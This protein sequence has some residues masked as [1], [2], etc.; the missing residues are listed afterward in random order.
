MVLTLEMLLAEARN[1]Q[2][3]CVAGFKGLSRQVLDTNIIDSP[4]ILT[5]LKGGELV[6][7]TGYVLTNNRPMIRT[8]VPDLVNKGCAGLAFK[9]KRYF[10]EIPQVILDQGN[11]LDFPILELSYDMRMSDL[12]HFVYSNIFKKELST[13]EQIYNLY[14][15]VT[16]ALVSDKDISLSLYEIS[17]HIQNPVFL[18]DGEMNLTAYEL[19]ENC[20]DE[21]RGLM[22][23]TL[24]EAAL[25][26]RL[27]EDILTLY[28]TSRFR[29]H[30]VVLG[31][32]ER[33]VNLQL[34]SL[35][36]NGESLGFL[37]VLESGTVINIEHFRL[38][39]GII[40][41]LCIHIMK[42]AFS[43]A[44]T[45]GDKNGFVQKVLLDPTVTEATIRQYSDAFGFQYKLKRVCMVVQITDFLSL[46]YNRRNVLMNSVA[47]QV[48]QIL[49]RHGTPFHF[50]QY[51][52]KFIY[53]LF[54]SLSTGDKDALDSTLD[55]SGELVS[56]LQNTPY[57]EEIA[58]HIGMSNCSL[59]WEDISKAYAR[60][61][62]AIEL[63]RKIDPDRGV[64][65]YSQNLAYHILNESMSHGQL[66]T[67]YTSTVAPLD[68]Y[69][70]ENETDLMET[71]MAYCEQSYNRR[72]TAEALYIH[73]NTL[74]Y[75]LDKIAEILHADL[76]DSE[77]LHNLFLGLRAKR[78]LDKFL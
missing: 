51:E 32:S 25:A 30:T 73:R 67:L 37:G 63:G 66:M 69:D 47:G 10:N 54:F 60:A 4:E 18:M 6:M 24:G 13:Q 28:Q 7:T 17:K 38:I 34:F 43:R 27:V 62:S 1:D 48:D 53:F 65:S 74:F 77:A 45:I 49:A 9:T 20:L 78:L 59:S 22:Q 12:A 21:H 64:Y 36:M 55:L 76:S 40:P 70:Q 5:W 46:A 72:K 33:Q 31:E 23:L 26:P 16:K 14:N 75:R 61:I 41:V 50:T 8:I 39:E 2:I 35:E 15:N 42:N 3:K 44:P 71:L 19:P 11:E 52:D 58:Y 56:A 29:G 68:V 57:G